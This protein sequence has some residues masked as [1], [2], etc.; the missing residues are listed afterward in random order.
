M[1]MGQYQI[2]HSW[3]TEPIE[4]LRY[5]IYRIIEAEHIAP[6]LSFRKLYSVFRRKK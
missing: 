6:C 2:I 4:K 1:G 5:K 3:E